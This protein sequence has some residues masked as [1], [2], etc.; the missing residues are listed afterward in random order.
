MKELS[1]DELRARFAQLRAGDELSAPRFDAVVDRAMRTVPER[2]RA[3]VRWRIPLALSVAAALVLAVAL[4]R[5]SRRRDFIAPPLSTWTSPTASL[6]QMPGSELL[7][8]P[9]LGSSA[10]GQLTTTFAQR[11]RK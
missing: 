9:S 6:L 3:W 7:A 4:A 2:A 8:L 10:L 11:E 1:D 5:T